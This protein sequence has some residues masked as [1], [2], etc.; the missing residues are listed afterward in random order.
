M[1]WEWCRWPESNRH[2]QKEQQI[3]SLWCLP[4]PPQ[5]HMAG[6]AGFEPTLFESKS[7]VTTNYTNP[8]YVI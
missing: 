8:Q 5:R 2:A 7:N 1:Y 4:V 3:L 6:D